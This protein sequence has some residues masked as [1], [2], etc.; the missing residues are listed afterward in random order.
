[1]KI[2]WIEAYAANPGVVL[3]ANDTA[4]QHLSNANFGDTFYVGES[5]VVMMGAGGD[6]AFVFHILP[7]VLSHITDLQAGY[8]LHL[9]Y[10]SL[11]PATTARIQSEPDI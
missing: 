3:A 5:F 8:V 7:A 4:G 10:C 1:M 11:P 6:V 9:R 2:D